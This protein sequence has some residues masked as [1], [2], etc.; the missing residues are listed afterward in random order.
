MFC[1]KCGTRVDDGDMFCWNCGNKMP[2]VEN[3]VEKIK[4]GSA[5]PYTGY[6][7]EPVDTGNTYD[8]GKVDI[9][10]DMPPATG[11]RMTI[12]EADREYDI[13]KLP[14]KKETGI[15]SIYMIDF[16]SRLA[17]RSNIPLMI[18]LI[19]NVVLIGLVVTVVC[20]LPVYW[21]ILCGLILYIASISIA[22]S[23]IGEAI[24]RH[25]NGCRKIEEQDIIERLYP[26][27]K[28]VYYKAK[29]A[30]PAISDDVRL[31]INDDMSPNAF[32]TG[33]KTM[34]V[35]RGLLQLS[36]E[37]IKATLGHEFGHLSH[38]DT[39]RI[40]VVSVGNT[41]ITGIAVIIQ[42]GAIFMEICSNIAAAF[43]DDDSGFLI[44]LFGTL[45]RIIT[46]FIINVFMKLWNMIGIALCMKTSRNNE[47]E[48]DEFSARLGYSEG[49][50]ELLNFIGGE[51]PKGLFASLASSHPA[52]ADR[53]AHIRKVQAQIDAGK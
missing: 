8:S 32:A 17:K 27:F 15:K 35:T 13:S 4:E 40:L 26:I 5:K 10:Y 3:K 2:T 30:N 25:Q 28:E 51:K 50:I 1:A 38:K 47:Y 29:M 53:I 24:L 44:S 36:D 42:V 31:F 22:I 45:S 52:G 7:P 33:R 39:D 46:L 6:V 41:V 12:A 11:R 34:C 23:S 49:L 16:M 21:G 18:Y 37:E 43:T 14:N 19:L 20:Q 48:A 9:S